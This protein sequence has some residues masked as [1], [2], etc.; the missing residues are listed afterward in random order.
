[1]SRWRQRPAQTPGMTQLNMQ[2]HNNNFEIL[3]HSC[4]NMKVL[5]NS[6]RGVHINAKDSTS[7]MSE[8]KPEDDTELDIV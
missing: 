6:T 1:M 5:W 8:I 7:D 3:P 2:S 4:M